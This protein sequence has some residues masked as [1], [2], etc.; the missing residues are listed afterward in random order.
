M[1][2]EELE[3]FNELSEKKAF[4]AEEFKEYSALEDIAYDSIKDAVFRFLRKNRKIIIA[5]TMAGT[6]IISGSILHFCIKE[7]K[8]VVNQGKELAE[9]KKNYSEDFIEEG[10]EECP[11]AIQT[12]LENHFT[13]IYSRLDGYC[14]IGEDGLFRWVSLD[15]QIYTNMKDFM[16]ENIREVSY[17]EIKDSFR[18]VPSEVSYDEYTVKSSVVN[19]EGREVLLQPIYKDGTFVGRADYVEK[20]GQVINLYTDQDQNI[21]AGSLGEFATLNEY[22]DLVKYSASTQRSTDKSTESSIDIETVKENIKASEDE[23]ISIEMNDTF[24]FA[25]FYQHAFPLEEANAHAYCIP[26]YLEQKK[27]VYDHN[28]YILD[29]VSNEGLLCLTPENKVVYCSVTGKLYNNYVNF[30]TQ[31]GTLLSS[32]K[33][34]SSAKKVG[35]PEGSYGLYSVDVFN[36]DTSISAYVANG[37]TRQIVGE[38]SC[39]EVL[40]IEY[41]VYQDIEGLSYASSFPD[42]VLRKEIEKYKETNLLPD[43]PEYPELSDFKER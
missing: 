11:L 6:A 16:G 14:V 7:E 12:I 29:A 28:L 30:L 20:D 25:T 9:Q 15:G 4:S 18:A 35:M 17:A 10:K 38:V 1:K 41:L 8:N 31:D 32:I 24:H 19:K 2:E 26:K 3:K 21:Y 36:E 33:D 40:G 22:I 37:E 34:L 23:G 27:A 42:L 5:G 43:I 39:L 13:V